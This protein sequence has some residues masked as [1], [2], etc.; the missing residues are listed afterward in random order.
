MDEN[1]EK[2]LHDILVRI[3]NLRHRNH[4]PLYQ[5]IDEVGAFS[6]A[7]FYQIDPQMRDAVEREVLDQVERERQQVDDA[8]SSLRVTEATR[9]DRR[10][11]E[12]GGQLALDT[13]I[14]VMKDGE[15]DFNRLK[16]VELW[17]EMARNGILVSRAQPPVD[18]RA[19][20]LPAPQRVPTF[21]PPM[22]G[23]KPGTE[24]NVRRPDGLE[25]SIKTP[26]D[27]ANVVD[28]TPAQAEPPAA[29][30]SP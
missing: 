29:P 16:A 22:E 9:L 19:P 3:F 27:P 23:L 5:A 6:R 26:P 14:E 4:R 18:N 20:Q 11:I 13:L 21:L 17:L 10:V 2:R 7:T 15:S 28:V 1:E 8:L 30:P 25:V 12:E 24:V